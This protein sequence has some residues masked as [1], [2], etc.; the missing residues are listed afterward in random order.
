MGEE[1]DEIHHVIELV[2]LGPD[3]YYPL[4][5]KIDVAMTLSCLMLCHFGPGCHDFRSEPFILSPLYLCSRSDLASYSHLLCVMIRHP[6]V[7]I[8]GTLP[9]DDRS[10][11]S[12]CIH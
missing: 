5:C 8:V 7:I 4:R 1:L 6:G 3:P 10:L 12:S 11:R 2:L 9:G